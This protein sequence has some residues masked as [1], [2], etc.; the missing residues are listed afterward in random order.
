LALG[1]WFGLRFY[2]DA[3][4]SR[5]LCGTPDAFEIGIVNGGFS[6]GASRNWLAA[7]V[8]VQ[9][10][11]K[12]ARIRP[13][14]FLRQGPAFRPVRGLGLSCRPPFQQ[15]RSSISTRCFL[16]RKVLGAGGFANSCLSVA[17]EGGL[18]LGGG[19]R[20]EPTA[21]I[22]ETARRPVQTVSET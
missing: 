22:P 19:R 3:G 7:P 11:A 5:L 15:P 18:A 9:R 8:F 1:F 21:Q 16:G 20:L 13:D 4:I 10:M 14:G 6:T 2:S 17:A 12:P